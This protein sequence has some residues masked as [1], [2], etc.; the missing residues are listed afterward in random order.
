MSTLEN[1]YAK[2]IAEL[3]FNYFYD[4]ANPTALEDQV[5]LTEN[6][7][8]AYNH[9][10]PDGRIKRMRYIYLSAFSVI[11]IIKETNE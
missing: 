5:L 8:I 11:N 1:I 2:P 7:S 6:H 10:V 3:I 9:Y 4:T